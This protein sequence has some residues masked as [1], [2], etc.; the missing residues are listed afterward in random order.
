M[1]T[2]SCPYYD[3][4]YCQCR[5]CCECDLNDNDDDKDE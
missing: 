1:T 3:E 2:T 5:D 4:S